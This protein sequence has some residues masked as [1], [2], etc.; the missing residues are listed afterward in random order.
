MAFEIMQFVKLKNDSLE[1]YGFKTGDIMYLVGNGFV[2]DS[3]IDPYRFRMLFVGAPVKDGHIQL[4][5]NGKPNGYTVDARN[6]KKVTKPELKKL[7]AIKEADFGGQ[8]AEA[9]TD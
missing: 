9:T 2:H 1:E 7:E 5:G 3:K 6:L 4:E 8:T